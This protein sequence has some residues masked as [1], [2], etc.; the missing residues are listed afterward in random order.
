[1]AASTDLIKLE[2]T[3]EM[4]APRK[5]SRILEVDA[6]LSHLV[7]YEA[8]PAT[9]TTWISEAE[10]ALMS[11]A[12]DADRRFADFNVRRVALVDVEQ[13]DFGMVTLEIPDEGE[14]RDWDFVANVN[15]MFFEFLGQPG[16]SAHIRLLGTLSGLAVHN[17]WENRR[18]ELS[19]VSDVS[20]VSERSPAM[21]R[22]RCAIALSL[23]ALDDEIAALPFRMSSAV[24]R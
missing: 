9:L 22:A 6:R 16:V 5:G 8:A 23:G 24:W 14:L 2:A 15:V 18:F 10:S 7:G 20:P 17:E 4:Q 12:S 1:M 19:T 11:S 21:S 3:E 13:S